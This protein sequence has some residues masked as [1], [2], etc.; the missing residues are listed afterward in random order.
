MESYEVEINGKVYPIKSI[1]NLNG[2][3]IAP[4]QIHG[5]KTVPIVRGGEGTMME[6]LFRL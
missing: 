3:T 6:V 1:R 2:H 5:G 4:Y